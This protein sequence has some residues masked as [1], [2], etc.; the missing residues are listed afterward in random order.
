MNTLV[1]SYAGKTPVI[2]SDRQKNTAGEMTTPTAG[3]MTT[4]TAG[5]MT[6]PTAGEMT[7]PNNQSITQLDGLRSSGAELSQEGVHSKEIN[8]EQVAELLLEEVV[9]DRY[10]S[11]K[12]GELMQLGLEGTG[13]KQEATE[14]MQLGLEGTGVKQEATEQMEQEIIVE[15]KAEQR[16]TELKQKIKATNEEIVCDMKQGF[17]V[18]R[19]ENADSQDVMEERKKQ[20]PVEGR[21]QRK[22]KEKEPNK[23]EGKEQITEEKEM[24][25]V[26]Q[27]DVTL[28]QEAIEQTD[29]ITEEIKQE[30]TEE[31]VKRPTQKKITDMVTQDIPVGE[32]ET[33]VR[34]KKEEESVTEV[35]LNEAI[36]E[37]HASIQA[38]EHLDMLGKLKKY[39]QPIS[40][41]KT[42]WVALRNVNCC[43]CGMEFSYSTKKVSHDMQLSYRLLYLVTFY[44]HS[45]FSTTVLS[46]ER[47]CVIAVGIIIKLYSM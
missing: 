3:E 11:E 8:D 30:C 27:H 41:L 6:T 44:F 18:D 43:K 25:D 7:T 35:R 47:L 37:G 2:T 17:F 5:E 26:S 12:N 15:S 28:V 24:A 33:T 4:P 22:E 23:E 13:V 38:E 9:E 46:V 39:T 29:K 10:R 34:K 36:Y 42:E 1:A 45:Y 19:D 20:I 16:I 32:E 40:T 14:L 21:E 31:V